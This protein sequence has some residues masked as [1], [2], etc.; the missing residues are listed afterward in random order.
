MLEQRIQAILPLDQ[1]ASES[2][3]KISSLYFDDICD[4]CLQDTID[5]NPHRNK[6]RIR[7]YNDSLAVIKLEV[8][9]KSYNRGYK[10]S[11]TISKKEMESIIAGETIDSNSDIHSAR[12][13]F[14]I[15]IQTRHLQPKVNVTYD[16]KAYVCETGNVRVTF[17]RNLRAND[18]IYMF[19]KSD[20][21]YDLPENVG[22]VLEVKYDE[23]LP[24]Y[25]AQTLE[26]N[27]LIQTSNSKYGICREYYGRR[28]R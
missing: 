6:Y 8:K 27:N 2:G 14:N 12:N 24:R 9:K 15:A 26:I 13:L 23:V 11:D 21:V 1:S 17:D 19:G 5:G 20:L 4:T 22:C 3:Y 7:I 25:I 18:Q 28:I 16:R 10:I